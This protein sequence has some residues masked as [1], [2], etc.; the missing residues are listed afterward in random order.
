MSKLSY[1]E[2]QRLPDSD[3]AIPSKRKYPIE[4]KAHA[5]NALAR[6]AQKGTPSEIKEVRMKVHHKYPS[7]DKRMRT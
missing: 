7:I 5:R 3:F 1:K 4:N 6:V 2:R